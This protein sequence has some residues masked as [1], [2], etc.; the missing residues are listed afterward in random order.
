MSEQP[1]A[2]ES[3]AEP[4]QV[5]ASPSEAKPAEPVDGTDWKA[6]ARKWE[7]QAKANK[8]AAERLQQIEDS[9]KSEAE[10]LND[11]IKK[12]QTDA[13]AAASEAARL[14]VAV[15]CGLDEAALNLLGDGDEDTLLERGRQISD[16]RRAAEELVTVKAEIEALRAGRA[17]PSGVPVE[18]LKPGATPVETPPADDAYPSHWIPQ[19]VNQ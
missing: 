18:N 5:E 13:A 15:K 4:A 1:T 9:Q 16:L 19:R 17:V 2:P 10:R 8:S 3:P 14:R 6:Q 11:A 12:A 7:A